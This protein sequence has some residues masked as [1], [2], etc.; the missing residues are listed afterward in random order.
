M[1]IELRMLA[2]NAIR[3]ASDNDDVERLAPGNAQ[4]RGAFALGP[5][6][7]VPVVLGA[8][9]GRQAGGGV[10]AREAE[11]VERSVAA[12][13]CGR[14]QVT[15]EP[16]VLDGP[17]HLPLLDRPDASAVCPGKCCCLPTL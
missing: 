8:E 7:P 12:H 5:D 9:D 10:E 11:P 16:V 6:L 4:A 3:A 1:L 13:Q 15:D 17:R 2:E 14:L